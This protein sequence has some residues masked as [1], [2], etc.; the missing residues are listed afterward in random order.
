LRSEG[1]LGEAPH[2]AEVVTIDVVANAEARDIRSDRFDPPG[3]IRTEHTAH[4][5]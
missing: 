2:E 4:P 5:A 3:D 1:E